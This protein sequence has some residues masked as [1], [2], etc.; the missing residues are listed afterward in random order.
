[1]EEHEKGWRST[2]KGS[3]VGSLEMEKPDES[4]QKGE[5]PA[6]FGK[7]RR[8]EKKRKEKSG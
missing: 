3:T 4:G 2:R 6:E 5:K 1:V 8:K 7:R